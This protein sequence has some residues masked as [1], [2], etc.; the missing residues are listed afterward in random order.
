MFSFGFLKQKKD[1]NFPLEISLNY[2]RVMIEY[3]LSKKNKY[4]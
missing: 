3:K 2:F 1:F 4:A